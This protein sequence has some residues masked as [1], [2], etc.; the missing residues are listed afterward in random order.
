VW[1]VLIARKEQELHFH[2]GAVLPGTT[3]SREYGGIHTEEVM[4]ATSSS[5]FEI[6]R[7]GQTLIVTAQ[8]DLRELDYWQIEAGAQDILQLLR[9]GTIKDVVLDFHKTDY[10]GSTALGFFVRLWKRIR[11]QGGRM[12]FCSVSKHEREILQVTKLDD[13]WPICASRAEA[14]KIVEG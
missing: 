8:T 13:L 12:A 1:K 4:M 14:L 7:E 2:E 10:Y 9:N 3:M 6:E 11:D 5:P